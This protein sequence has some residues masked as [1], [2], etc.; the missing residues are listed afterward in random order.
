MSLRACRIVKY[1]MLNSMRSGIV[2]LVPFLCAAF[3]ASAAVD[4]SSIVEREPNGVY[5]VTGIVSVVVH[6]GP[7]SDF[8]INVP[9]PESSQYQD[10][11]WIEPP[12]MKLVKTY[13]ESGD[14]RFFFTKTNCAAVPEIRRVFKVR[15]YKIKAN[16]SKV[17]KI[18]PYKKSSRLYKDNIR[19][20][21]TKTNLKTLPWLAQSVESIKRVS[22]ENP[23]AY[24]RLAYA[25]IVTNFVYGVPKRT[26][27][28][29]LA[30]TIREM[31]GNCW[32]LSELYVALLRAGGIPSR[33][34]ACLRPV[35]YLEHC[36]AEFYLEG[37]GWIPV[38]V[39]LDLDKTPSYMHF[40]YYDDLTVV[41]TRGN[42]FELKSAGGK[43]VIMP[44][45]Q[46][47]CDWYWNY[48]G[49]NGNPKVTCT[50]EGARVE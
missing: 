25:H 3:A 29:G 6:G 33:A 46:W 8:M 19:P 45:C 42:N 22:A 24:A 4:V 47:Y 35:E 39:T 5:V 44:F 30:K 18:H 7:C 34:T 2:G 28:S 20:K 23:L 27:D 26:P 13:K 21:E 17:R 9:Y 43:K 32:E 11:E 14:K 40:G 1:D 50:F 10:I 31:R 48:D 16:F 37:Y 38:D 12:P 41:L 15:F 36:W 49:F